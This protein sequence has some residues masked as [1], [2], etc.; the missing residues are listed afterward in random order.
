MENASKA[1]I[2]AGGM[3]LAILI[4]TLLIY[5]WSLF[6]KYQSSKDDLADIEDT[7]KFNEQF[8]NYDRENVQGYEL[9]SLV[10]KVIDYNYRKSND[11]NAKNDE[12]YKPITIKINLG[13]D[14]YRK[15]LTKDDTIRLFTNA[16]YIQSNTVNTFGNILTGA[17][18][19]QQIESDYGGADCA[20][21]IA[22]SIDS[23]FLSDAQIERN[24]TKG[25]TEEESWNDAIKV[26][27]SYSLK[28]KVN[29]KADLLG[30][31]NKAYRYYEY[32]QFK[33][34]KFDSVAESV[35][36]DTITGRIYQMEFTFTG[37]LY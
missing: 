20:T 26:F 23:I 19:M 9:L 34:A 33:R 15:K 2:M 37:E 7:A 35:K 28:T 1:L 3:L 32:V 25:K 22:K 8:A 17:N 21:K 10:N 12:K 18:G 4:V 27:N 31:K 29:T 11:A 16:T 13:N 6:S 14:N 30:Q 5:A 36:Y 24:K